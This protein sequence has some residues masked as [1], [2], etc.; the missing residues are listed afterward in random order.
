MK[1]DSV[2]AEMTCQW[3]A[4][5]TNLFMCC[6]NN[7]RSMLFTMIQLS[8]YYANEDGYFFRTNADLQE[9][10]NLSE[11]LVRATIST[12]YE[13]G[14]L[15]V[16]S[17]GAS[18]GTIPNF[19]KVND[20]AFKKWESKSIEDCM[21]NPLCKIATP[22]YKAKGWRPAYLS[23]KPA[24]ET[25]ELTSLQVAQKVAEKVAQSE[26]NISNRTNEEN[27]KKDSTKEQ[28][29][30][31]C[32]RLMDTREWNVFQRTRAELRELQEQYTSLKRKET[33][34][35][36]ISAIEK[37]KMKYFAKI[38]ENSP[39]NSGWKEVY[40]KTGCGHQGMK[41]QVQ[42]SQQDQCI[43][44]AEQM[45]NA[46]LARFGIAAPDDYQPHVLNADRPYEDSD[47]DSLP[48]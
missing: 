26:D 22:D 33:V 31:L 3:T 24:K 27:I 12:L 2:N 38:A 25:I 6:D 45:M 29:D 18:R 40:E 23:E 10:S 19:F 35:K 28:E 41:K 9:E 4:V 48:F 5:P 1:L 37:N 7:V 43:R 20:E 34:E 39:Y 11:G 36:R 13:Q 8:S 47:D 17:V 44:E 30:L 46:T 14:V 32:K 16:K 42:Q 21:K 15:E